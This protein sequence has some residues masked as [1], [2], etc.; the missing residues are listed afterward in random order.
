MHLPVMPPVAPM[1]SRAVA[2]IPDTGHVEPKWDGFRTIVFRDGDEV[3]LGSRNERPLT[4][5]FPEVVAAIIANSPPRCVLDGELI[6][7]ND[8]RLDFAAL[9]LRLHPAASRVEKLAAQTPASFVAFDLLALGEEN[10]M[11]RPLAYRRAA[12]VDALADARP[13]VY[14]TP[15]TA[16]PEL[17]RHWFETFEG[18]GLDGVVAKA[19]DAPYQPDKRVMF[20]V[21]HER[22]ADCVVAG[23][24]WH[25]SGPVVGSLLL[26]LFDADGALRHVGVCASFPMARR[27]ELLDELASL[28]IPDGQLSV[29][30]HPWAE[31]AQWA[32]GTAAARAMGAVSRWNPAK[33]LSWVPLRP[34]RVVE[35]SY[36]HMAGERFRHTAQFR[37][38]RPD[39]EPPSCTYQQLD[40][41]VSYDLAEVLRGNA[42]GAAGPL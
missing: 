35:V 25:V 38:W 42:G 2:R 31:W 22:T 12:L 30:T 19:L 5:Y 21:K 7:I 29:D 26:G 15:A 37:R 23:F 3:V 13:P 16:D 40:E 39:R 18:A 8:G 41:P 11:G 27:R 32:G 28:R 9:Q 1:L 20:K 6:L 10:L 33:D 34:Q 36:D 24:R 14:L 4:R 17:A